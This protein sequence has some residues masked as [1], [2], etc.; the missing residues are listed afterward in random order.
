MTNEFEYMSYD[1]TDQLTMLENTVIPPAAFG[2]GAAGAGPAST[3]RT[4]A[5]INRGRP[6]AGRS[7]TRWARGHLRAISIAVA[8][9]GAAIIA[10]V[11]VLPGGGPSWPA[12]VAQVRTE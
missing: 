5:L 2:D 11:L 8:T 6:A 9:T 4:E 7:W 10:L 1:D 3:G 12:S